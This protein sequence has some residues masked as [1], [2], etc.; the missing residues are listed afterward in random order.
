MAYNI[1][2]KK[3]N[4]Q[5]L[6]NSQNYLFQF[7]QILN[8]MSSR[9]LNTPTSDNITI[10]FIKA[11]IPHHQAAIYMCQNLLRFTS[12]PP[13]ENIARQIIRTQT[14]G[15]NQMRQILN[16]TPNYENPNID[17]NYYQYNFFNI[18]NSMVSKM[19]SSIRSSNINRNFVSEMIPHHEGAVAMCQNLLNYN[20]NPS[21][22][23]VA[24]EII[25]QQSVGIIKLK[26][27]QNELKNMQQLY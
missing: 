1:M 20:I 7:D 25:E 22:V 16:S 6:L 4:N 27:I 13:L 17:I 8:Q 2:V 23:Q 19:V 26:Q 3:M 18:T 5:E 14:K 12:Y 15:I 11:M 9:M 24:R 10:N 21:L